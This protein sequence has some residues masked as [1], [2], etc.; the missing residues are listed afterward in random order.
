MAYRQCFEKNFYQTMKKVEFENI[1]DVCC[2]KLTVEAKT[3]L[4]RT[5]TQFENRVRELLDKLT[6]SDKSF[7]INYSPHPQAFPDIAM[8]EYGVEV[9]FTTQDTWRCIANSVLE[10]QR[11]D[12]V[13]HIYIIYGKMGGIPNV[14]WAE[15]E[16]SVVHVRT[17]HVP[18]F[19]I[20]MPNDKKSHIPLFKQ[21]GIRYDD[22]RKL[23]M[24]EKMKY[25]RAYAR[26]IHP[27]GRLWWVEDKEGGENHTTPAE[28]RLYTNLSQEEK[29]RLRAE[30]ALLCPSIVKSG[31]TR[32]KYDDI[33]LYLLTYHG[34][35]CHQARD[36]FSAGSVANPQNDDK[37]GLYIER[38]LK[39]IEQDMIEA[40]YRMDDALFVEY[41]NESVKPEK[42]I[43]RWLEKA[44]ELAKDW[45]PSDTLFLN[46]KNSESKT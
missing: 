22:F 19:E 10:T 15:W 8:G 45:R 46:Y 30:G 42:R 38:A 24:Q 28:A 4:F 12:S 32:N 37:G 7:V 18:R 27:D 6:S 25:I 44:D 23:K 2:N 39:L 29:T 9:K 17:S 11:I 1:L 14:Q 21:M 3:A 31:R 40:A 35:I 26:K 5:S 34:V 43:L 33:V 20:E 41:W 13:K 16:N 36:L